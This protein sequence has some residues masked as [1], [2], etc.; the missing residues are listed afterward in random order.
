MEDNGKEEFLTTLVQNL[1]VLDSNLEGILGSTL[2]ELLASGGIS[3]RSFAQGGLADAT[4]EMASLMGG[5][6]GNRKSAPAKKE[7]DFGKIGLNEDGNL[8]SAGY[9]KNDQRS[10][11]VQAYKM[12]D[13]LYYVGLSKATSGYGPRLYDVVMEAVS[14]KGAMLTSDRSSVSGDAKKVWEYYFK[15]RGDVKK[16]P[17][18]P[19]D[20]TKN[21]SLIDPKLYGRRETWPPSTD[22]AWVL[23]SGYSKSP[24][25]INDPNSVIRANK[26]P[27]V[28]SAQ[29][30][31]Q[32]F[33]RANGGRLGFADG[34]S[35]PALVS[36]GEAYVPP[37]VAKRIGYDKLNKMNQADKNGMGRFSD[38]GIS[39]FKGPGTGTSDS[40]PTSLPVGSFII[41]EK[42]T[43]ALGLNKGGSVGVQRFADGGSPKGGKPN[44]YPGL[45]TKP[46]TFLEEMT[47]KAGN[48]FKSSSSIMRN[49]GKIFG[50]LDISYSSLS[51]ALDEYTSILINTGQLTVDQ[52]N[53]MYRAYEKAAR[54]VA[55]TGDVKAMIDAEKQWVAAL[56]SAA[57]S[58]RA[59]IVQ[60]ATGSTTP[61]APASGPAP[62][63]PEA[64]PS[65][66]VSATPPT[67]SAAPKIDIKSIKDKINIF[68]GIDLGQL[69]DLDNI[70]KSTGTSLRRLSVDIMNAANSA[71]QSA[72]DQG[73]SLA[74]ANI[75][76]REAA[77][78]LMGIEIPS[79]DITERQQK[80]IRAGNLKE[81]EAI[82]ANKKDKAAAELKVTQGL[83]VASRVT[84]NIEQNKA[85]GETTLS[86]NG[87]NTISNA[88]S[89]AV[90]KQAS[91][92]AGD[93][94][95]SEFNNITSQF[96][97]VLNALSVGGEG[98]IDLAGL[99]NLLR[100]T[101]TARTKAATDGSGISVK[102]FLDDVVDSIGSV[103]ASELSSAIEA[104]TTKPETGVD[105][106]KTAGD[107]GKDAS[108]TRDIG[109]LSSVIDNQRAL[110][111]EIKSKNESL[112]TQKQELETA[113][114]GAAT[115]AEAALIQSKID[116]I[117]QE[118]A[119]VEQSFTSLSETIEKK[120]QI[121][122]DGFVVASEEL[123]K[124]ANV[125][126][127]AQK[128]LDDEYKKL[129]G[130]LSSNADN[131]NS[132]TDEQKAAAI[133]SEAAYGDVANAAEA[134][135]A[136]QSARAKKEEEMLSTYGKA[137]TS[138]DVISNIEG[139]TERGKAAAAA[140]EKEEADRAALEQKKQS[141]RD[142]G[143]KRADIAVGSRREYETEEQFDERKKAATEKYTRQ[144]A[145]QMGLSKTRF[146][147]KGEKESIEKQRAEEKAVK[148]KE[149][150]SSKSKTDIQA[151]A[152][153]TKATLLLIQA[154]NSNTNAH[155][156]TT[157]ALD[158]QVAD[159][160]DSN[161]SLETARIKNIEDK[162][163]NDKNTTDDSALFEDELRTIPFLD[164]LDG[165][166]SSVNDFANGF[167]ASST[168][169][170]GKVSRMGG[171]F[172]GAASKIDSGIKGMA[173][174]LRNANTA[175]AGTSLGKF[176]D[177]FS[178]YG[179][180]IGGGVTMVTQ[181]LADMSGGFDTTTG[182]VAQFASTISSQATIIGTMG[183]QF[184]PLGGIIGTVAGAAMGATRA[185][186]DMQNA[187]REKARADLEM[188]KEDA[189]AQASS[190]FELALS[191]SSNAAEDF[192][193]GLEAMTTVINAEKELLKTDTKSSQY[194][195]GYMGFGGV[196]QKTGQELRESVQNRAAAEAGG[197]AL[198]KQLLGGVMRSGNLTIDQTKEKLGAEKF[199][200]LGGQIAEADT[201]FINARLA[202]A[203]QMNKDIAAGMSKADAEN[204]YR[205][206]VDTA[207]DASVRR[208]LASQ[209][210]AIAD[211]QYRKSVTEVRQ[212]LEQQGTAFIEKVV[213]A[214]PKERVEMRKDIVSATDLLQ[215]D[216]RS[217]RAQQDAAAQKAYRETGG[218][219]KE[220]QE[221]AS[222]AAA[223]VRGRQ[224]AAANDLLAYMDPKDQETR[225]LKAN[226]LET[227]L[228]EQG[229]D[230]NAKA[231][232][233]VLDSLRQQDPELQAREKA[234]ATTEANTK[235]IEDLTKTLNSNGG[236]NI[237][238][239]MTAE[240][241]LG[242]TEREN[243]GVGLAG[244]V[245]GTAAILATRR[246]M[247][248][249]S[250]PEALRK[251]GKITEEEYQGRKAA[252]Q[253][254]QAEQPTKKKGFFSS[255][256]DRFSP[257]GGR[258]EAAPTPPRKPPR[259]GK[260]A[261]EAAAVAQENQAKKPRFE[262]SATGGKKAAAT[263]LGFLG[264]GYAAARS[265]GGTAEP[266]SEEQM[267]DLEASPEIVQLLSAI[268]ANTRNCCS[269]RGE[270]IGGTTADQA[271][272]TVEE[273][274]YT[275]GEIPQAEP[276]K[277][278]SEALAY[279]FGTVSGLMDAVPSMV[280]D[281][282][283]VKSAAS[284]MFTQQR[285]TPP[286]VPATMAD[287]TGQVPGKS[288]MMPNILGTA[289]I[290]M[291]SLGT[292]M[293]LL[294]MQDQISR[295]NY[296]YAANEGL[297]AAAG[298]L[299]VAGGV[300]GGKTGL[301]FGA[302]G[303]T[304]S[305]GRNLGR[306]FGG[307]S[308]EQGTIGQDIVSLGS[309]TLQVGAQA[310]ALAPTTT[311]KLATSVAP[312]ALKTSLAP[313]AQAAG[314]G[315]KSAG[316][317][318]AGR[319]AGGAASTVISAATNAYEAI[320]DPKKYDAKMRKAA[321]PNNRTSERFIGNLN[322]ML[323]TEFAVAEGAAGSFTDSL[324]GGLEGAVDP[325]GKIVEAAYVAGGAWEDTS[326]LIASAA[327][328]ERMTQATVDD[329]KLD[330]RERNYAKE[331]AKLEMDLEKA[332]SSG[333]TTEIEWIKGK[334]EQNKKARLSKRAENNWLPTWMTGQY[335]DT[336][337]YKKYVKQLKTQPQQ[338]MPKPQVSAT[339]T[340][341]EAYG[342]AL[343]KATG[344][345]GPATQ[346]TQLTQQTAQVL[347]ST[348]EPQT[349]PPGTIVDQ[350]GNKIQALGTP[351]SGA[352]ITGD[353]EFTRSL[354]AYDAEI[355]AQS[356]PQPEIKPKQ[357][358]V[359]EQFNQL[360]TGSKLSETL[361]IPEQQ[362][363]ASERMAE[364]PTFGL[365]EK[366]Q[367]LVKSQE[368]LQMQ[369]KKAEESGN[370]EEAQR[371]EDQIYSTSKE[372]RASRE[373]SVGGS[374]GNVMADVNLYRQA[375]EQ[376]RTEPL[377]ETNN[378]FTNPVAEV[379]RAQIPAPTAPQTAGGVT[380]I[381]QPG[382]SETAATGMSQLTDT[383]AIGTSLQAAFGQFVTDLQ[384]V[385]LPK[386]PDV[387]TMEG[388][389]TVEV[390][391]N[392]A[393]V[394][395][396]IEPMIK[397][398]IDT[399]LGNFKTTLNN[400]T[401]G[402]ISGMG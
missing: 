352:A 42:A 343:P 229:L 214:T 260:P 302:L 61:S 393:E 299:N 362:A 69:A 231:F 20:W 358:N 245:G 244:V 255:L 166:S 103:L 147:S 110:A 341:T 112:G 323:G 340:T 327:K 122:A 381:R 158:E 104:Q 126:A 386:I 46:F 234:A 401:E 76:A 256:V 144:S 213:A 330:I 53:L 68:R 155:G 167:A 207:R 276:E 378:L 79:L 350:A 81:Q 36:N 216:M 301:A 384:S 392:G 282:I 396:S 293:S 259:R 23:Q 153:E 128:T 178:Q 102:R 241:E 366:E 149:L 114:A 130:R 189:M 283:G 390:I 161:K 132:M 192:K 200:A 119:M 139:G 224:T 249:R 335:E 318:G 190:S 240:D 365:S 118:I 38:G 186:F 285:K 96:D 312:Q 148:T 288:K 270:N 5:L 24:S 253:A 123:N 329:T 254:A 379:A 11:Y 180:A 92:G 248:N 243:V 30:A 49:T 121:F 363:T 135:A 18:E 32:Y 336:D 50:S 361:S 75:A 84:S 163:N 359:L 355:I 34:G 59:G 195:R 295:G 165:W 159:L 157:R 368:L 160:E 48:A 63:P 225:N 134:L 86:E 387:V 154:L 127:E 261:V 82:E 204:K 376:A 31:L 101:Q 6:Y 356:A 177:S 44:L 391:L 317:I 117:D 269:G 89:E 41:R 15:N 222:R 106:G 339:P 133:E 55:S 4:S 338:E 377:A 199:N 146:V 171:I 319:V 138:E 305:A 402:G 344:A 8:I 151:Q 337:D 145:V 374:G 65:A 27:A 292:G 233:D 74:E 394:L 105:I 287:A 77:A 194:T 175:F 129:I 93:T 29:M 125:E 141:A 266:S 90:S 21:Q 170:N 370:I 238:D 22:P 347:A 274:T 252:Q 257:S 294:A 272:T 51:R 184:G 310:G 39:V 71:R 227:Q 328:T 187:A 191:N 62:L 333:D 193:A 315:G 67:P 14:E 383:A 262:G 174:A 278:V 360:A 168:D 382:T 324:V 246:S 221:A 345:T 57:D 303:D 291:Q 13:N 173:A 322:K 80:E 375:R 326:N 217:S 296:G 286:P 164:T 131:W 334:L 264:L 332:T 389:H 354:A 58:L 172:Q 17:L 116:A 196:R 64:M 219:V 152:S 320:S 162:D 143:S 400:A 140:K 99:Q 223:E 279:E 142:L 202:A 43:K 107:L 395:K 179:T 203:D 325:I 369:K 313:V 268:E 271:R 185:F 346:G 316:V 331:Q 218:T 398:L 182:T 357:P 237:Y 7:K 60:Q 220:K 228:K 353:N 280:A 124:L 150:E 109:M 308:L 300:T 181:H 388:K 275:T 2:N 236:N 95:R 111:A 397:D 183:A 258:Q 56:N 88:L 47:I 298:A 290:G 40:I 156:M 113:K 209:E 97:K 35:V 226:L 91:G 120:K 205:G 201:T 19:E 230:P 309:D 83:G 215:G 373:A 73:K 247:R 3:R 284:D 25:L 321:D 385:Q 52:E 108:N 87:I 348:P 281:A 372:L 251:A 206:A 66:P 342:P 37:K 208:A 273:Q 115:P 197:A 1:P 364:V 169:L 12:K 314:L 212:R 45:D 9:Y 78:G 304:L 16:T 265:L 72:L 297:G 176:A 10:G 94:I 98:T 232:K 211:E 85:I 277:T 198:S 351:G 242:R 210:A 54:A 307:Q 137:T 26:K 100:E 311:A 267:A 306:L 349:L 250:T 380:N 399:K 136:A 235:A 371:I 70:A 367:N 28:S 239:F 289:N 33:Q 188:A 263:A